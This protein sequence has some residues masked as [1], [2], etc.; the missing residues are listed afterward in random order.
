MQYIFKDFIISYLKLEEQSEPAF[1]L[2]ATITSCT[3]VFYR[4]FLLQQLPPGWPPA[5]EPPPVLLRGPR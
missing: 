4:L 2:S 5:E 1:N 3:S